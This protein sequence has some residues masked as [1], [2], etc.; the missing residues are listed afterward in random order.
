MR[1]LR[2]FV[3]ESTRA[4]IALLLV[5]A[6]LLPLG[7]LAAY[8]L[9]A[10]RR[11][12][13]TTTEALLVA[14]AD[15]L[16][17]R[18]DDFNNGL[19]LAAERL[20]RM[21]SV[22]AAITGTDAREAGGAIDVLDLWAKSDPKLR[23]VA[24]LDAR[25]M[26][27]LT[28]EPALAGKTLWSRGAIR[29]ASGGR[30]VIADVFIDQLA[31]GV[32]TI[33]YL[34]PVRAADGAV[35]GVAALWVRAEALWRLMKTANELAGPG[36]YAALLD[37]AGIR[38]AHTFSDDVIFHPVMPLDPRTRA[39][40]QAE[41]RFGQRTGALVEQ[42]W[43]FPEMGEQVNT[44]S[45]RAGV[46]RGYG[47]VTRQWNYMVARRLETASWTVFY[48]LPQDVVESQLAR[49]ARTKVLFAAAILLSAL[50]VG[51][52]LAGLVLDPIRALAQATAAV[53]GGDLT[54]RVPVSPR[55]DELGRLG[56]N[57]NAMVGQLAVQTAAV[58]RGRDEL[59]QKVNERTAELRHTTR[60]LE[61]EIEQGR[62]ARLDLEARQAELARALEKAAR[63]QG[64]LTALFQSGIIGVV[65]GT[66]DGRIIEINDA[67]LEML[68]HS[69]DEILSGKVMWPT[70]TPL[71]WRPGDA[72][73]VEILRRKGVLPLREKEYLH[74]DGHR[75]PVLVGTTVLG[76]PSNEA[77]SFVLD[78]TH[79]ARAALAIQ[80]LGQVRAS[81]A[82]FRALLEAVPDGVVIASGEGE[83]VYV[84]G[85]TERL[86]G[87][88][89]AMLIGQMIEI[90][91]PERLRSEHPGHRRAYARDPKVRAMGAKQELYG[92][93]SDGSELPIEVSLSPVQAEQR[94]VIS[95]IRDISAR[96][97]ADEQR[98]RLAAI[99]ESSGDAIIGKTLEGVITSWNDA[100][101]RIFGYS[102]G[103]IVGKPITT[104]IPTERQHEEREILATLARGE[105]VEQ[106]DTVRL[107]K[108][109]RR[110]DVSLT[111]S[112]VRDSEGR[113]IGASK[114][115]RDITERRR[116]ELAL[117]QAKDLAETASRELESFSYSVAHD[118][119]APL[120][121]MNGFAHMLL[122]SY[123][124]KLDAGG[125]D[126]LA[127]IV[128]NAK[129]MAELIDA[130]LSL[131]RVTRSDL[132]TDTVDLSAM[133]RDV[134]AQL[135]GAEPGRQVDARIAEGLLVEA[136]SRLVRAL[137]DN[138][139]GNAWKFT[140]RVPNAHIEFDATE[141]REGRTFFVRDD[142]AGFDMKYVGKL[143]AAFQRL[144]GGH[145]FAGTGIGLATS[146]RIVRRHG[147][148]IWAEGSVGKGATFHFTLPSPSR[149][150]S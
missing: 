18:L 146:Q 106:F 125:Q 11:H 81:E 6:S 39:S 7:L 35:A 97:R 4:K 149:S 86:F 138:L 33:A 53:T 116:V 121:A 68:G 20:S 142:G 78:V 77:I 56:Q 129:K 99:V 34:A 87:Y 115:V 29:E 57:F 64:R 12:L 90:L 28:T 9:R 147:G 93:R 48:L 15:E 101:E 3:Q 108:D 69:R 13:M 100:A 37:R 5:A 14:R 85:Q 118:L 42:V 22:V 70:L 140:S 16:V 80:H 31:G 74:K 46:F 122:Q 117:A 141:G 55:A 105:R 124:D 107:R 83:I 17:R 139:L 88:E 41:R 61:V 109:G 102:A 45:P 8:D 103:D 120:R 26:V 32:P 36:S 150:L 19:R 130:L 27:T 91:I 143:F 137:L 112:P 127:E 110:L 24:V 52:V 65:V 72:E 73:A 49:L 21:P 123:G 96:R 54:V 51:V 23:G 95:S 1:S 111:S 44:P 67:L 30:F 82:R 43:S 114:I 94:L 71:E 50:L 126:W 76:E 2:R 148:K 133:A 98:F 132:R 58:S 92:R 25:G 47:A 75:I 89:R 144:H 134:I 84:N 119:R 62:Q 66:L 60:A 136:D 38:I 131:A 63:S 10:S 79:N 59:E 40:L 113:L 135:R 145:E 104:L 128:L